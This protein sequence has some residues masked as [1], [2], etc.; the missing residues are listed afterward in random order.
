[1][2][3]EFRASEA[4]CGRRLDLVV[5]DLGKVS[6]SYAKSLIEQSCVVVAGGYRKPSYLVRTDD[7]I[8]VSWPVRTCHVPA[9]EEIP[10]DMLYEDKHIAAI[11][12]P[13]GM[14]VHPAPG[15][16]EG[17][18]VNALLWRWG[19]NEE[20][21]W[22]RP[23]IVHRLD[24]DTSGVLVIAK[25]RAALEHLGT[26]FQERRVAKEYRAVVIGRMPQEEG[27][28]SYP[29]GRHSIH[30]KMMS[31]NSR[32][33]RPA[34]TA[35]KVEASSDT[36]SVVQLRPKTGRTHQLRV[37]L[38]AVSHPIVGDRVY[39]SVRAERLLPPPLRHFERQALH[40]KVIKFSHPYSGETVTVR[41]P[42]PDDFAGLVDRALST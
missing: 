9:P 29:I 24:K 28:I 16:W 3:Q 38:A 14:V 2:E 26:Q 10:L 1:M 5:A 30:R 33:G 31:I 40:A 7:V 12:K 35:Y 37:H 11:N 6:R 25:N 22:L 20:S 13:A 4:H 39:G 19:W 18:V 41:A 15:Q 32:R 23:G 8:N 36:V 42:Y 17:T 27:L 34:E 21:M